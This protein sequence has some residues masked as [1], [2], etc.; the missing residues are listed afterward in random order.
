MP[1]LA[2]I[3]QNDLFYHM[4]TFLFEKNNCP[5]IWIS[6]FKTIFLLILTMDYGI[7]WSNL[8]YAYAIF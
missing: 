3:L 6:I 1:N 7:M 5:K 4:K 8:K 2:N